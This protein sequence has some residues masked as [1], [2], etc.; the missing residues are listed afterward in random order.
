MNMEHGICRQVLVGVGNLKAQIKRLKVE[1]FNRK[2]ISHDE[3]WFKAHE[4]RT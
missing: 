3:L 2:K 4:D 1:T